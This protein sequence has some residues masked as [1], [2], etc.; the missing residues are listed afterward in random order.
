MAGDPL[1]E[2]LRESFKKSDLSLLRDQEI[3]NNNS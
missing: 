3:E 2:N 1:K